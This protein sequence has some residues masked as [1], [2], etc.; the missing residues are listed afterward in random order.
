MSGFMGAG[1]MWGFMVLG[2]VFWILILVGLG[3][4]VYALIR[5]WGEPVGRPMST[6]DDPLA[7][8]RMRYARGDITREEFL[9]IQKDLADRG[10]PQQ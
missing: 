2:A 7:M 4:L 9:Q 8:A 10:G 6:L 5:R 3:F 1:S